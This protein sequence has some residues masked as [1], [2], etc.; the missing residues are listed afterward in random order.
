MTQWTR[1]T[2]V[3]APVEA[4]FTY[5]KDPIHWMETYPDAEISR[6]EPKPDGLG[7]TFAWAGK[8]LG[9]SAKVHSSSP[10]SSPTSASPRRRPKDSSSV[11]RSN[12]TSRAR[13]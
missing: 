12:P 6:I 3:D 9:R 4:V 5:L 1:S 11:G 2:F 13:S 7:T 8:F 10:S